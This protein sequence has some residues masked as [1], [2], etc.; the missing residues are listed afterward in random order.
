MFGGDDELAGRSADD[1]WIFDPLAKV[2]TEIDTSTSPPA[3]CKHNMVFDPYLDRVIL[4]GGIGQ[5][6]T[7]PYNQLWYFDPITETW[8]QEATTIDVPSYLWIPI[9]SF[10]SVIIIKK[11]KL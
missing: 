8:S 9:L 4:F 5:V 2:W 6:F 10:I 11:R 3:V 7:V 1:T